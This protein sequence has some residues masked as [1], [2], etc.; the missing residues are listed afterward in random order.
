MLNEHAALLFLGI[1]YFTAPLCE[2][3]TLYSSLPEDL[4]KYSHDG[5]LQNIENHFE[6]Q[7]RPRF[8]VFP[9]NTAK[10]CKS[11]VPVI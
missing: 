7:K 8:S 11:S 3:H 2:L 4:T 5:I 10:P 1:C 9:P 6:G